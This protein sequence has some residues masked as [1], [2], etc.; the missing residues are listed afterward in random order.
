MPR[1]AREAADTQG[2]QRG[3]GGKGG[4]GEV[5]PTKQSLRDQ[6]L[7]LRPVNRT[8]GYAFWRLAIQ[9][10]VD[11]CLSV[12]ETYLRAQGELPKSLFGG[13]VVS[14][15]PYFMAPVVL[16]EYPEQFLEGFVRRGEIKPN[17]MY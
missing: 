1:P 6:P 17:F 7:L 12:L 15:N 8:N 13:A 3:E 14:Q 4:I 11:W 10:M 16:I 2:R 9:R 5:G